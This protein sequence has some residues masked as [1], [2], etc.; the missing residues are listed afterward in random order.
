MIHII[1]GARRRRLDS[2]PIEQACEELSRMIRQSHRERALEV[3]RSH[4]PEPLARGELMA[5]LR[6][7]EESVRELLQDM[8]ERHLIQPISAAPVRWV[9]EKMGQCDGCGLYDHHLVR[10]ECPQ[11]RGG[12]GAPAI[13]Q[14]KET[15]AR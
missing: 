10:G 15:Q 6:M 5:A 3:F 9:L 7:G 2:L 4:D 14:P 8:R 12:H 11:C 1:S 13:E